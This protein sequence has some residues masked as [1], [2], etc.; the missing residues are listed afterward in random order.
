MIGPAQCSTVYSD[1][2]NGMVDVGR[3]NTNRIDSQANPCRISYAGPPLWRYEKPQ[4]SGQFCN[5]GPKDSLFREGNPVRC[6]RQKA[7]RA[8]D[9]QNSRSDIENRQQKP[10]KNDRIAVLRASGCHG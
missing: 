6:D 7:S 10:E 3:K 8:F 4:T 1:I 9:M 5:S 2:V